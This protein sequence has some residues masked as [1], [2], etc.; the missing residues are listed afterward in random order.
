MDFLHVYIFTIL[1]RFSLSFSTS[2]SLL[3]AGLFFFFFSACHSCYCCIFCISIYYV[4]DEKLYSRQLYVMGHEAQRRMMA[5]NALLIGMSGLG[6]EVAKNC[7]LAGIHGLTLCDPLPPNFYD[8][9]GNFYL[10]ATDVMN[11]NNN[12][13][14]SSSRSRR[15]ALCKDHLAQLNPYV[16]VKT[17]THVTALTAEQILPLVPGMTV[18]VVTIPLP[19]ALM[20]AL[21]E[22]CRAAGAC[23]IYSVTMSVFGCVFC[24]FG[25]TFTV[26]DKDGEAAASSQIESVLF[27]NPAVVKVLEDQGRH[28][29]GTCFFVAVFILL[30]LCV[31][32]VV[33]VVDCFLKKPAHYL[34]VIFRRVVLYRIGLYY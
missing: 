28:G 18:V 10:T 34:T 20:E 6:V 15:D 13:S 31:C 23:F 32:C 33:C 7:I 27:E 1:L 30:L 21:N 16:E 14:G 19:R 4:V 24:D 3:Y 5:S 25:E 9:G 29:L 2:H 17:A 22:K 11:N 12:N 26:T 8:L